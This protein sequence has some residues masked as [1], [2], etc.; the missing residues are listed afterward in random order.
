[1]KSK[2]YRKNQSSVESI[3]RK[4]PY[5]EY[6]QLKNAYIN[7]KEKNKKLKL[8]KQKIESILKEFQLHLSD[9]KTSN[10]TIKILFQK[11]ENNYKELRL[12]KSYNFTNIYQTRADNFK[13]IND[14]KSTIF[15]SKRNF[16]VNYETNEQEESFKKT[17]NS[18]KSN[19]EIITNEYNSAIN[20][21]KDIINQLKNEIKLRD[22]LFQLKGNKEYNNNIIKE[23]NIKQNNS[24]KNLMICNNDCKLNIIQNKDLNLINNYKNYKLIVSSKNCEYNIIKETNLNKYINNLD[25]VSNIC[26]IKI[27]KEKINIHNYNFSDKL[28]MA[29]NICEL[30]ILKENEIKKYIN[31]L[32]SICSKINEV[33]I[34]S[35]E[36]LNENEINNY[37]MESSINEINKFGEE[38]F[39]KNLS[40]NKKVDIISNTCQINIISNNEKNI[41]FLYFDNLSICQ[42]ITEL[43]IINNNKTYDYLTIISKVSEVDIL[44]D[45]RQKIIL[46]MKNFNICS[47]IND[48]NIISFEKQMY[49]DIVSNISQINIIQNIIVKKSL[50]KVQNDYFQFINKKNK[51]KDKKLETERA[52]LENYINTLNLGFDN[53]KHYDNYNIINKEKDD[54]DSDNEND[55]LEC[56]PIPSFILCIQKM[57]D[58][59]DN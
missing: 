59:N 25:I 50:F 4:I 41:N 11:V 15:K 35:K 13:I 24:F 21:Y 33:V 12:S 17:I 57:K 27:L 3:T 19:N 52:I 30:D 32:F 6:L 48:I 2:T 42:K 18:M 40:F 56:E 39:L 14:D 22:E 54:E 43:E 26:E 44:Y 9:Y 29:S 5:G 20:R 51:I 34:L 10:N 53:S 55:R 36:K 31:N 28:E 47:K 46:Y 49:L 8:E 7:L 37:I 23:K 1:M 45:E 16:F 58:K 38:K